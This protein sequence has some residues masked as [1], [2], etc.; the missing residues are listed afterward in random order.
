MKV[1]GPLSTEMLI[2]LKAIA[3][4]VFVAIFVYVTFRL[5]RTSRETHERHAR[6][7]LGDSM[8]ESS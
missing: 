6:I 8:E 3:M 7:P 1:T 5:V 2:L 4:F